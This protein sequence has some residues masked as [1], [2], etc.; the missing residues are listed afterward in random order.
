VERPNP[1]GD[2]RLRERRAEGDRV[3]LVAVGDAAFDLVFVGE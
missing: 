1:V 3:P 2:A